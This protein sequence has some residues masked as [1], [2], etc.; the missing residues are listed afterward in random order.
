MKNSKKLLFWAVIMTAFLLFSCYSDE[1]KKTRNNDSLAGEILAL[2]DEYLNSGESAE[3]GSEFTR[4]FREAPGS[5]LDALAL[6][7]P[8]RREQMLI[9]IGSAIASARR[10]DAAAYA[11]YAAALEQA[12]GSDLSEES[13][14]MLGFVRANVEYWYS[15]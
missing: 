12:E 2:F 14:R 7:D 1:E 5:T 15:H 8:F 6:A 10:D 4:K 13:L 9:L 3:K 11:R